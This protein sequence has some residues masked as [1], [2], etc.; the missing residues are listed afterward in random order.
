MVLLLC[1]LLNHLSVHYTM[2]LDCT[3]WYYTGVVSGCTA[4]AHY[5]RVVAQ[6]CTAAE[7]CCMELGL[8]LTVALLA[9]SSFWPVPCMCLM[10]FPT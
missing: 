10:F 1:I 8:D 7:Q 5:C 4:A 9:Q 3:A 6:Y 2:V